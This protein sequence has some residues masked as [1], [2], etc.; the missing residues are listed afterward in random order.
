MRIVKKN[1]GPEKKK[2]LSSPNDY[3][4]LVVKDTEFKTVYTR[5]FNFGCI[6]LFHSSRASS[7]IDH[8]HSSL[9]VDPKGNICLPPLGHSVLIEYR[10]VQVYFQPVL[11]SS[12]LPY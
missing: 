7:V 3:A 1:N 12:S 4:D 8:T 11:N 5:L 2:N 9:G 10:V 6:F